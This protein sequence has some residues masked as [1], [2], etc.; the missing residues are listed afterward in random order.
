MDHFFAPLQTYLKALPSGAIPAERQDA[1]SPLA[2]FLAE[3]IRESGQAQ[4]TFICTHNSRRS[5]FGQVWARI[6][7][8]ALGLD[9][10]FTYS[11]GTEATACHPHTLQALAAA[12]LRIAPQSEG[13]NPHYL[14]D[15]S[16]THPPIEA[17]SKV[18]TD[19][20]NPQTGFAAVMT[21]DSANEACPVVFGAAGRFPVL[22]EDPKAF[23]GTPREKAAY[24]E[25]CAQVSAEMRFVMERVRSH[26]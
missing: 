13:S 12:G 22:Y 6:W 10:I 20:A 3:E 5:H 26:V 19:P 7:A 9:K 1:L 4:L 25:R 16:E 21:C 14:L 24:A 17:W 2:S 18:Y 23:D 15:F 8:I 11:G